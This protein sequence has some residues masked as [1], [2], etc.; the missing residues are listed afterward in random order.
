MINLWKVTII[1]KCYHKTMWS[2]KPGKNSNGKNANGK[3]QASAI[4]IDV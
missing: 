4:Y 2:E 3:W 1:A